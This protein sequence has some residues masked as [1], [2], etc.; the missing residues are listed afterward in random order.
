[1]DEIWKDG[2]D[3]TSGATF[4]YYMNSTKHIPLI[5]DKYNVNY[6]VYDVSEKRSTVWFKKHHVVKKKKEETTVEKIE[7]MSAFKKIIAPKKLCEDS[8]YDKR[9]IVTFY[10]MHYMLIVEKE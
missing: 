4:D 6:I 9:I 5:V 3:F 10:Q 2:M 7:F 8:T 1:M